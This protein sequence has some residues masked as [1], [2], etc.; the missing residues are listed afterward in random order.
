MIKIEVKKKEKM[1]LS[2]IID[3]INKNKSI[4]IIKDEVNDEK[5]N[6]TLIKREYTC[7]NKNGSKDI[8]IME[9]ID[10]EIYFSHYLETKSSG[11]IDGVE[12]I[13]I[14]SVL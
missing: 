4:N 13:D 3:Y 8:F 12:F 5:E 7:T 14:N 1:D 2:D 6:N 10:N 11:S 9:L